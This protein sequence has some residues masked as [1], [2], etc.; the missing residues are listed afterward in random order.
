MPLTLI[1]SSD[2]ATTTFGHAELRLPKIG[3]I[4]TDE[5][6]FVEILLKGKHYG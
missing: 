3:Q 1:D 2:S 5:P 4:P 6:R